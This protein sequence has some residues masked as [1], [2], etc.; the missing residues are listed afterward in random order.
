V[1][2]LFGGEKL[3]DARTF[4]KQRASEYSLESLRSYAGMVANVSA[5]RR[6]FL[7]A[8]GGRQAVL[9]PRV[10]AS[11]RK[12]GDEW[13]FRCSLACTPQW[14]V[15]RGVD[16]LVALNGGISESSLTRS[17]SI[18]ASPRYYGLCARPGN[19][20]RSAFCVRVYG[21]GTWCALRR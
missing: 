7:R 1:Y 20:P 12:C 4:A 2:F 15:T 8:R 11:D 3:R 5:L 19:M 9:P 18:L 17:V 14:G 16:R 10:F 21:R 6:L 13:Q